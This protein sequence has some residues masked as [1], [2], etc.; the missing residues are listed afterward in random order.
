MKFVTYIDGHELS[1][2]GSLLTRNSVSCSVT[3]RPTHRAEFIAF[4]KQ[5]VD[6][7]DPP[8]EILFP[9]DRVAPVPTTFSRGELLDLLADMA[10]EDH[11]WLTPYW[12]EIRYMCE[13]DPVGMETV[14]L[15]G[16]EA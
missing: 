14:Y 5:A 15:M 11:Y 16:K 2:F 4:L 10:E 7:Y 8:K 1:S 12:E 9:K 13:E 6:G 3:I